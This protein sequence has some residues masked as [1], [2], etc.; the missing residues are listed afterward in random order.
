MKVKIKMSVRAIKDAAGVAQNKVASLGV[1]GLSLPA[2]KAEI[3][4]PSASFNPALQSVWQG[5]S[6]DVW[7][8]I[9]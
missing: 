7:L 6:A 1:T 5:R 8:C 2:D 9:C 3:S 4:R